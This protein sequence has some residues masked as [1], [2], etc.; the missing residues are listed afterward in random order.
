MRGAVN[1]K[2]VS[3]IPSKIDG[4]MNNSQKSTVHKAPTR[5]F[6]VRRVQ[7]KNLTLKK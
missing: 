2:S 1:E 5:H 4:K 6:V 7:G 3:A